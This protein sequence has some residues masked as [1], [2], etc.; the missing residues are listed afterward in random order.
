MNILEFLV[1]STPK[2][3]LFILSML[4][5]V[6]VDEDDADDVVVLCGQFLLLCPC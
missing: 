3:T 5:E 2:N 1:A 6:V 4:A